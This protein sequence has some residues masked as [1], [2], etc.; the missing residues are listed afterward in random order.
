MAIERARLFASSLQYGAIEE[1]NRLA[2]EIHDT[3]AQGLTGIVLHLETVDAMLS[4]D[5]PPEEVANV[6][7]RALALSRAN[8]EEARRSMSN[9]RAAPLE[10]R[11]LAEALTLLAHNEQARAPGLEIKF[12]LKGKNRPLP[13]R[14]ETGLYRIAQE[15][16]ANSLRHARA[17]HATIELVILR[18]RV[19]LSIS[20]DGQGFDAEKLASGMRAGYGI[21]GMNERARL[22]GGALQLSSS[23]GK[24]THIE[25]TVPLPPEAAS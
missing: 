4:A 17:D 5:A 12:A 3:L 25:V 16:V 15:A 6:V 10:S 19:R 2:R 13:D 7:A 21:I 23:P 24:G 22:L 8:L 1:R 9:L 20:D 14:L 11:T 18:D